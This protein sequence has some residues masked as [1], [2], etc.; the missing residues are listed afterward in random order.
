M[1]LSRMKILSDSEIERINQAS[2]EILE[3]TGVMIA[4]RS[5]L[6]FLQGTGAEVDIER[7]VARFPR[8]LVDDCLK[9]LPSSFDLFDRT[10][11]K[12]M[13]VGG[14][15]SKCASGHNAIYIVDSF[16]SE[17]RNSTLKDVEE[18]ARVSDHLKDIDIVGVPLM[19][20]DVTPQAT[21][22][23]AVKTLFENTT[24]P[25]FY[26][27]ESRAVNASIL[28]MMKAVAGQEDLA[29]C[30]TAISQLSST[31][32]LF[33]EEGAVEA[34][35]D[36]AREGVP[37]NLLPEPMTGISAPYTIAGLLTVH[38]TEV[39]S[40]IVIAQLTRPGTPVLYGSS[41]T[42]FDLMNM[43]A[44]IG[45]PETDLLRIAG[46]QMARRYR[47]PS[48]TTAPNSDA[49]THDEQNAWERTLSN[50]CAIGAD[51]DI[52]MNSGMFA[53]GL[54]ISLEQLVLDDEIN[55]IIRRM[56]RGIEV[57]S[58]TI[59][60]EVIAEVG[61]KGSFLM[62]DHTFDY[63][64]SGEFRPNQV[65]NTMNYDAWRKSGSPDVAH[66]ANAVVRR[67]LSE[68]HAAPLDRSTIDALKQIIRDFEKDI[69][70]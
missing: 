32:P 58:E 11:K 27:T 50:L 20:Q 34:L 3:R 35:V 66:Q 41:W 37:L 54:T 44:I 9:T 65:A 53:T 49:N 38:N 60:Q 57:T 48:H 29:S 42:T 52:V 23:Y 28:R 2:L 13:T 61:H 63:L 46:S 62:Q 15:G 6:E 31:S 21:L 55:G 1:E 39:L 51:N 59:G 16:S 4:S 69:H 22:L 25:I 56:K 17:R 36:T 24:K 67:I 14:T 64:R 70:R 8:R 40:G 10:G 19:P 26:S 30:P 45:G 5:V 68:A 18:F 7:S 47:M 43:S 12:A 33:W